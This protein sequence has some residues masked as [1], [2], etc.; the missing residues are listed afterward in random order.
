MK[1][2]TQRPQRSPRLSSWAAPARP[3]SARSTTTIRRAQAY[4]ATG[5]DALFFTGIKS[6]CRV[7]GDCRRYEAANR[8]GGGA[9]EEL[10]ALDYL[11][12]QRVRIALQG[13]APIAAATQA[14]YDTLKAP[15]RGHAAESAQGSR[16]VRVEWPRHAR[17]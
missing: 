11:A 12:A 7:R 5:V 16:I 13:H 6:A 15:A 8:A 3:R 14:A 1:G 9:P 17:V 10:N 4:E 2:G